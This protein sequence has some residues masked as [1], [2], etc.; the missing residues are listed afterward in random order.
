MVYVNSVVNPFIYHH[1]SNDFRDGFR[2]VIDK[3]CCKPRRGLA[4]TTSGTS[5]RQRIQRNATEDHRGAESVGD[6]DDVGES[7]GCRMNFAD[8]LITA[9]VTSRDAMEVGCLSF[10]DR[11]TELDTLNDLPTCSTAV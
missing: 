6:I 2:D 3:A 9:Q 1:A 5:V 8:A 10:G 4:P 11:H 7:R